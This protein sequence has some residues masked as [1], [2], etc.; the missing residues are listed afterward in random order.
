[1]TTQHLCLVNIL[2]PDFQSRQVRVSMVPRRLMPRIWLVGWGSKGQNTLKSWRKNTS[3]C[4]PIP[5]V[6]LGVPLN[7]RADFQGSA[8]L[9]VFRF[10]APVVVFGASGWGAVGTGPREQGGVSVRGARLMTF[11]YCQE[12]WQGQER[13]APPKLN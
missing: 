7:G 8:L 13:S 5:D 3:V 4:S 12:G 10:S 11:H 2:F 9:P 1:M 6:R